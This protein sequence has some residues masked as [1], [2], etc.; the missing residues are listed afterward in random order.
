M[1]RLWIAAV[2]VA[3]LLVVGA[4]TVSAGQSHPSPV[5]SYHVRA[6]DTLWNVAAAVAPGKDRR[7]VVLKLIDFN[8]LGAP[9][10]FPGQTLHFPA[11]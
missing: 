7:D 10:I 2:L 8:H 5:Q 3:S 11:R 4:R 6:G 9:T 1:K